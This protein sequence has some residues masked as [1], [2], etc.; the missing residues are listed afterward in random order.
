[1]TS[2]LCDP[3]GRIDQEY[4]EELAAE[5]AALAGVGK[6][7]VL[8]TSGAI[9]AGCERLGWSARPR[10]LPLKQAAAAVGQGRLMELYA[11]AFGRHGRAVGQVLLTRHDAA[12]RSRY[13]NARNT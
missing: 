9:R 1:G 11:A 10:A 3:E 2:T 6:R 4:V 8:V 12:D 13:V 5:I 7:V